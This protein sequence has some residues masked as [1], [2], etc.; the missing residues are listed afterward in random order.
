MP[1]SKARNRERMRQY[2]LHDKENTGYV[3]PAA[4]DDNLFKRVVLESGEI[5]QIDA[6]GYPVYDE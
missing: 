6:D 1:L 2:R 3:Q 5:V 4:P